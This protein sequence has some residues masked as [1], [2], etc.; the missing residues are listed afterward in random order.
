[1]GPA[2]HA[3][4][5]DHADH[6]GSAP[7]TIVALIADGVL[8][9]ELAALGWLLVDARLPLIVAG[10]DAGARD[11]L[12]GAFLDLLPPTTRRFDLAGA[13]EDF[14]WLPEAT[15]LGWSPAAGAA[16]GAP[17]PPAIPAS[18]A[19]AYLAA[20]E[21]SDR[22]AGASWGRA[23]RTF[24]RAAS[25]GYGIATTV[26]A[27]RLE[28]VHDRLRS[29]GVGLNDDELSYLGLILIVGPDRESASPRARVIAA[30]YARPVGRDEHG[31][32]QRLPP[33]VLAVR[34]P[35]S[36]RLDH[37]SWGVMPE[38]A[39]R[40]GRK[41]GD[42]ERDQ[43]ERAAFLA[44]LVAGGAVERRAVRAAIRSWLASRGSSDQRAH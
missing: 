27:A 40:L 31:H 28:D 16:S 36:G 9:A 22:R 4:R 19:S 3:D 18:P 33:A 7:P 37:F 10:D 43:A 23:A 32:T 24:V 2:N 42:L 35:G 8:D 1:M 13:A 17:L 14:A 5:P 21:L 44:S 12:L 11:A 39:I 34:D 25:L 38:L 41:A 20:L 29:A 26:D 15:A 30:H 6:G